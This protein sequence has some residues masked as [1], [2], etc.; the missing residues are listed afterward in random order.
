M[1]NDTLK[2]GVH[3]E[4]LDWAVQY[5]A[6]EAEFQLEFI[7]HIEG[8]IIALNSDEAKGRPH[9]HVIKQ[10][11]TQIQYLLSSL[12]PYVRNDLQE[13][14]DAH[15]LGKMGEMGCLKYDDEFPEIPILHGLDQLACI[16][17]EKLKKLTADNTR[18]E[19]KNAKL[20]IGLAR[21]YCVL[22]CSEPPSHSRKN[23]FYYLVDIMLNA[24]DYEFKAK[25]YSRAVQELIKEVIGPE[26]GSS[27]TE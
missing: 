20:L 18:H 21:V 3:E 14:L 1:P 10:N 6:V 15:I 23:Y 17:D 11:Y 16:V 24:I 5:N 2:E 4:L 13:T 25:N 8:F 26:S 7:S 19:R 12:S 27:A 22:Y 9:T